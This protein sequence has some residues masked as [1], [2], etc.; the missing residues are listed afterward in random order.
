M[1]LTLTLLKTGILFVDHQQFTLAANDLAICTSF[2]DG[3]SYFHESIVIKI[4][5]SCLL[6]IPENYTTPAQIVRA[7]LYANLISR[8]DANIVHPHFSRNGSQN[9]VPILQF[10]PEHRI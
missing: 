2:F 3:S 8:Q 6:L 9:L 5:Q 1:R 7:H 4:Y 10:N